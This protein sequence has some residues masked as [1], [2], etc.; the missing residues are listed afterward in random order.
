MG[1]T[2]T[3]T[4]QLLDEDGDPVGPTPGKNNLFEVKVDTFLESASSDAVP[5]H[6][7]MLIG[8]R[9]FRLLMNSPSAYL[10]GE[11]YENTSCHRTAQRDYPRAPTH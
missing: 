4:V 8:A 7:Q 3:F 2:V 6:K 9:L 10:T 11:V 5:L 1:R